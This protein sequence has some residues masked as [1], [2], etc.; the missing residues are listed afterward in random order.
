MWY[1]HWWSDYA[2]A[3]DVRPLLELG[4]LCQGLGIS[5]GGAGGPG[6]SCGWLQA[7]QVLAEVDNF[8]L[9]LAGV[10]RLGKDVGP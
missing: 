6:G 1:D 9:A 5:G 8:P 3:C 7:G 10:G 2:D 4:A